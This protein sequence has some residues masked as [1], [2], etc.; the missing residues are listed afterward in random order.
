MRSCR[1]GFGQGVAGSLDSFGVKIA[2]LIQAP[3]DGV[4]QVGYIGLFALRRMRRSQVRPMKYL[5]V[6]SASE[7]TSL[8]MR[9]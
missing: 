2:V 6:S 8:N 1:K 4:D 5:F 3:V 9:A 7:C